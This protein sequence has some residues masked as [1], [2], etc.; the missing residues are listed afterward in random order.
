MARPFF[1]LIFCLRIIISYYYFPP[2]TPTFALHHPSSPVSLSLSSPAAAARYRTDLLSLP[3]MNLLLL[4]LPLGLLPAV[5][6]EFDP[7]L[8]GTWTTKSR[9]VVTGPVRTLTPTPGQLKEALK[10][11]TGWL[12]TFSCRASTIRS[13]TG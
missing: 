11:A 12:T 7:R 5:S 2:S 3:T 9:K 8:V 13:R 4:L 1:S 6:A 10:D